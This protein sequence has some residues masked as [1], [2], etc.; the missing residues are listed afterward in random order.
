MELIF[1]VAGILFSDFIV[2]FLGKVLELAGTWLE[3]RISK[4]GEAINDSN[5]KI[6]Q[7]Q[8]KAEIGEE[9]P[10]YQIGFAIPTE[11]ENEDDEEGDEYDDDEV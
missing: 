5:I 7:A 8:V 10:K 1:F 9:L 11:I 3:T 6:Q 4:M 2:P